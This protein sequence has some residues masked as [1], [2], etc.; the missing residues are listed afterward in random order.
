MLP[1]DWVALRRPTVARAA[2]NALWSLEPPDYRLDLAVVP[3]NGE[4]VAFKDG[5]LRISEEVDLA[6]LPGLIRQEWRQVLA[7]KH[8]QGKHNQ[9]AH[10]RGQ[11]HLQGKH[12]QKR[13]A[14][15]GGAGALADSLLDKAS[16][17]EPRLTASLDSMVSEVGGS[18]EGLEFRVKSK[19]SLERKLKDEFRQHPQWSL[20]DVAAADITDIVRYTA[21]FP[22]SR[23]RTGVKATRARLESSGARVVK[24]RNYWKESGGGYRGV[25]T[26][27]QDTSGARFELQF[28][29]SQ[30]F[31]TKMSTH[32]I[33]QVA[34]GLSN[35]RS[36]KRKLLDLVMEQE[37]MWIS[38]RVPEGAEDAF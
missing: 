26:V 38:V 6:A 1:P 20:E 7:Y 13:H 11:K 24:A 22:A 9:Q 28:H 25:N 3:Q 4:A 23:Y 21:V 16:G 12:N 32:E 30:S 14:G 18:L 5:T 19:S 36:G 2:L 34:R 15:T 31:R 27:F 35:T 17:V 8:L 10:G 29:T 33:Y 37:R